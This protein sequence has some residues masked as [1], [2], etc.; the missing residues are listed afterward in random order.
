MANQEIVTAN[1]TKTSPKKEE[2]GRKD[3]NRKVRKSRVQKAKKPR[4]NEAGHAP[5]NERTSKDSTMLR[6][7]GY[8]FG[9]GVKEIN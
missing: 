7:E 3:Q 9:T 2:V 8:Y 4:G 6:L 5:L 1:T